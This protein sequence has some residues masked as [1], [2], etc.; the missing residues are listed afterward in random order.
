MHRNFQ[1]LL[2]VAA[3]MIGASAASAATVAYWRFDNDGKTAGQTAETVLDETANNNDG[4]GSNAPTYSSDV[5]GSQ[6][7]LT[8]DP[9]TLSID[10]ERDSSQ[11]IRV[12][13]SNSLDFGDSSFTIEAYV[14]FETAVTGV[15]SQQF[16]VWKKEFD[17]GVADTQLDY[18]I[19]FARNGSF[20]A[21][22]NGRLV[23][24][25]GNGSTTN[26]VGS[27]LTLT[28]TT[29]WHYVSVAFDAVNDQVRFIIDD[30]TATIA[31]T[32]TAAANTGELI[33]GAHKNA[34]NIIDAHFD[35]QIDEL[36]ISNTF[37][38][39]SEL[40]NVVPTPAALPAGLLMMG[41]MLSRRRRI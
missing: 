25:Q 11:R 16:L 34:S 4:S 21:S 17:S 9:N 26:F 2:I 28:D 33:I 35:G 39:T 12:E 18:G 30:Q 10:L 37:L 24:V 8:G 3:V 1:A 29:S 23:L 14:K 19:V 40:L 5:F 7:P 22:V 20:G 6:V 32:F 31:N 38:D 36:R 41:A 13:D 27:G 15:A